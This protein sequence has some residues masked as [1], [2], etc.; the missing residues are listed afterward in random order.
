MS[1][2]YQQNIYHANV[3][4]NLTVKNATRIKSRITI[5]VGVS[6]K[7]GKNTICVIIFGKIIFWILLHV[8]AKMPNI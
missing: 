7:I 6:I 5:D 4:V 8:V 3:N 1:Q 2:K